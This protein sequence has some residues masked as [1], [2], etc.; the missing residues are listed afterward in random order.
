MDALHWFIFTFMYSDNIRTTHCNSAIGVSKKTLTSAN[1]YYAKEM[2][3]APHN[4]ITM[5][6]SY[7]GYMTVEEFE[8]K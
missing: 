7:L 5:N 6:I 1:I 8:G 2:A 3:N 4:S